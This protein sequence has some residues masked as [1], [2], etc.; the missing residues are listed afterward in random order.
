MR[1]FISV[2]ICVS[3]VGLAAHSQNL[4]FDL[5][6]PPVDVKVERAG[7]T[8]PIAEIPDLQPGDR[9]WLH[10]DFPDTQ[11]VHYLLVVAFLRGTTN[12]PPDNWFTKAET[13]DKSVRQEGIYV[14]V[15]KEAQQALVFLAPQAT[16]DFSSLRAA[17]RGRPGAFVRS[18]QDL[19]QAS[20]DR[21]RIE[22]YVNAVKSIAENNPKELQQR[23]ASLAHDLKIKLDQKCFDKPIEQQYSCLTSNPEQLILDDTNSQSM[24]ARVSNGA[25][26]DLMNQISYSRLAGGGA[27]SAYIGAIIDF[28]RIMGSLHTAQYQY[29]PALAL[30]R[31]DSLSL[32]LNNPPSFRKPQSVIVVAL[33]PVQPSSPPKV[34]AVEKAG[35]QC[36]ANPSLVLPIEGPPLLWA[37]HYAHDMSLRVQ[38]R[39]GHVVELPL[40]ADASRS[41]FT[42]D[43]AHADWGD[44]QS[45]LT[46]A[47]HGLWGFEPFQGPQFRLR[48]A[49]TQ[50]WSVVS[51]DKSAL[52][53]GREDLLHIDGQSAACVNTVNLVEGGDKTTPLT[54]RTTGPHTLEIKVPLQQRKPGDLKIAI[55]QHGLATPDSVNASSYEEAAQFDA[56]DV[57]AGDS[58]GTLR[59][60]R[61]DEVQRLELDGVRFA[62][63]Q[64][65]RHSDH[66]ELTLK[67]TSP[68][69]DLPPGQ[70]QA[71]VVLKD[72]R[73]F[74]LH[75]TV[76]PPRPRVAL[77]SKGVQGDSELSKRIHLAGSDEIPSAGRIIFSIKTVAPTVFPR[78]ETIEVAAND[79]SFHTI[80]SMSDGTLILQDAKTAV[81]TVDP[82]KTFGKSAFGPMQ[83][84]P[85]S[86][87]GTKGDWQPLGT[88]VRL[89]DLQQVGCPKKRSLPCVLG[90][91]DLFLINSL[92]ADANPDTQVAVPDGFTGQEISIGRPT[93]DSVYLYLRDDPDVRQTATIPLVNEISR[94]NETSAET[95]NFKTPAQKDDGPNAEVAPNGG[96]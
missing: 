57:N 26:A 23:S 9:L 91:K 62:A 96:H 31:G 60:K 58:T 61:L 47:V 14:T 39:A 11:S 56:F 7:K 8:L 16:G 25:T 75:A 24:L 1:F 90:G 95:K 36:L 28:G 35:D 13:W 83:F 49:R 42:I 33:P 94:S 59:G 71:T 20:Y 3:F 52:I 77:I 55:H 88:L 78:S 68:T 43:E 48:T 44:F 64:L 29:I 40:S 85:I 12:P 67:T 51:D 82:E 30:S 70:E 6:G 73:D 38:D 21:A 27:Y 93:S 4:G 80:L 34:R 41:G 65:S 89:P 22:L 53:V 84:R 87:Q 18:S 63:N 69:D 86:P 15:P 66:D 19:Q 79:G 17:V 46:G 10:P 50:N 81:A 76:M 45:E 37:T 92:S 74:Q 54:W 5:V 32:R 2:L 72:G